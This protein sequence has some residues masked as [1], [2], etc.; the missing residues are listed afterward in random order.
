MSREP[1]D[2]R[3]AA[4]FGPRYQED[5]WRELLPA[6][7]QRLI[8]AGFFT[9]AGEITARGLDALRRWQIEAVGPATPT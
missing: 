7:R 8:D 4:V 6:A 5:H 1:H 2:E 3:G 9:Q